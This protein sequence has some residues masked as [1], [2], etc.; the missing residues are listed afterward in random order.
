ML[1]TPRMGD[2]RLRLICD[3]RFT[4]VDLGTAIPLW[5]LPNTL[6]KAR[7]GALIYRDVKNEDRTG[8]VHE[9]KGDDDK[10]SS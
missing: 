7:S 10:M 4:I 5:R 6:T 8:Y 1:L 3:C 2:S 9:N